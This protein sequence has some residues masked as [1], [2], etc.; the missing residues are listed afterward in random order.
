MLTAVGYTYR[1]VIQRAARPQTAPAF[2]FPLLPA[3]DLLCWLSE[4]AVVL[5]LLFLVSQSLTSCPKMGKCVF[6]EKWLSS[7]RFGLW[8]AAHPTSRH[9]ARCKLCRKDIDVSTMGESALVSHMAGK[10]HKEAVGRR[11]SLPV[12]RF[13]HEAAGLQVRQSLPRWDRQLRR[14]R[15]RL[16]L[17]MAK[18][19]LDCQ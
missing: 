15:R 8:V 5:T 10:K 7:D 18:H 14:R 9:K 17:I 11:Q 2:Q 3:V 1:T 6:A 13:F 19:P 4:L 12:T 16:P